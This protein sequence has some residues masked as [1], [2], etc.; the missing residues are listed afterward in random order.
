ML[1]ASCEAQR[2]DKISLRC[3]TPNQSVFGSIL[4]DAFGNIINTPCPT[5]TNSFTGI[6]DFSGATTTLGATT[7]G[8]TALLYSPVLTA[9][10]G[11]DSA[12]VSRIFASGTS[13]N[14]VVNAIVG[15]A[16]NQGDVGGSMTL[17]AI[18]GFAQVNAST[19]GSVYAGDFQGF[20]GGSH[21]VTNLFGIRSVAAGG[22][23]GT[24]TNEYGGYFLA[25][26]AGGGGAS[27]ITNM[28]GVQSVISLDA[29]TTPTTTTTVKGVAI[30]D[31]ALGGFSTVGTSYGIYIDGSLNNFG[32]TNY[33]IYSSTTSPSK[34][35][36][37]VAVGDNTKGFVLKSPNGTCYRLTVTD[38]GV[39]GTTAIACP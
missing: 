25:K 4:I 18:N 39:L 32:T 28:F 19:T 29:G 36:G 20:Q 15:L 31:W 22:H 9:A 13:T 5:R 27:I 2:I 8:K 3:K 1:C 10:F 38:A 14:N 12:F 17:T 6:V 30:Q 33:S 34:F 21:T 35:F 23:N 11:G 24:T 37:D 16:S 7:L 26:N